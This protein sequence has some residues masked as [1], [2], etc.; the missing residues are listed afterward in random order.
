MIFSD[1]STAAGIKH[2]RLLQST[3]NTHESFMALMGFFVA[4]AFNRVAI[5]YIFLIFNLLE[6]QGLQNR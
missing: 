2:L 5:L 3:I 4:V 1:R 6:N